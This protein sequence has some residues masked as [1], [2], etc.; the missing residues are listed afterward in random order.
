[1]DRLAFAAVFGGTSAERDAARAEIRDR[2]AAAGVVS[3]SIHPLYMAMG[4][5]EVTGFTVPAINVRMMAYDFARAIFKTAVADD[6]GAVI[7]ELA[8]SEM[9]YTDQRPAEFVSVVTAAAVREGFAG[10]LFVQGD[11]YQANAKRYA[12]DPTSEIDA[13]KALVREAIAAG[14]GNIDVDC[15]TLVDL[16]KPTL[17]EQQRANFLHGAELT[18]RIRSVEPKGMTVSVGGEIGEV[19]AKNS[20]M[21]ELRAY[22]DGY[23]AE[24][25]RIAGP[26][27][28][29]LSKVSVQTGTSHGGVP[30]PDG[31]VAQ[32]EIDFQVLRDLGR[33]ARETYGLCG[34]VQH[35]A[36]TL[37]EEVFDL[38][39]KAGTAEIHLAT[40][41][42][43]LVLAHE[44]FPAGLKAEMDRWCLSE[45]K[46]ERKPGMTDAQF[47]YKTRKYAWGPFKRATWE[48]PE[49]ARQALRDAISAQVSMLFGKLSVHGTRALAAR[50]ASVPAAAPSPAGR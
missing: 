46:G 18:A 2:A 37:P 20:T 40:G 48:I 13:L 4:R 7:F 30:L 1:M 17:V 49:A 6:V 32:V 31:R 41:F 34:C 39:P 47:L 14:Y 36:S 28:V 19:G 3:A 44:A 9:G 21:G 25:T 50:H 27:A 16:S 38:F 12:S 11:H 23:R 33:V 43:N 5:G 15:S 22:M 42:Q 8:R 26:S 10:P 35:G 24:L 29:G 45:R